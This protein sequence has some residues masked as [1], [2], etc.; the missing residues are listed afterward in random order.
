MIVLTG[1]L[2]VG[3]PA[4]AQA[5]PT[6]PTTPT[7]TPS[8]TAGTGATQAP[9]PVDGAKPADGQPD[10]VAPVPGTGGSA[11][12]APAG[13]PERDVTDVDEGAESDAERAG[14][15]SGTDRFETA[16]QLSKSSFPGTA[17]V[18][19]IATGESFAD[20][21]SA[22]PAAV[23]VGGPLLL[24]YRDDLPATVTAEIKRVNPT[25]IIVVGGTAAVSMRVEQQLR[26]LAPYLDRYSG[27]DR[28]ATSMTVARCAWSSRFNPSVVM[29]ETSEKGFRLCDRIFFGADTA[30]LAVGSNFPDALA[31]GAAAGRI[32]APV[33]V[34]PTSNR[35]SGGWSTNFDTA[36]LSPDRIS[37]LR[38]VGGYNALDSE[39][40]Q[41]ASRKKINAVR[42]SGS[43][44]Y[45]TAVAV[46]SYSFR[47]AP[48]V[49]L[50]TGS[51]FPDA[52]AGAAAAGKRGAPLYLS[53]GDCVPESVLTDLDRLGLKTPSKV[54]LI[55]GLN[56]LDANVEQLG[57]C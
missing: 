54:T 49:Y 57:R 37:D 33:L 55:G 17:P 45:D 8:A 42:L 41:I 52:L 24:T 43:T 12:P 20:A 34:G 10:E 48:E 19:V 47:Q 56:A 36:L 14:R 50:A 39:W 23:K 1:L 31:A 13:G 40:E 25:Q 9:V 7:P 15:V 27:S 28:Y 32:A 35:G 3:V 11:E 53:Q 46:N 26:S 21:L 51:N 30:Y 18:V 5:A 29:T 16:V 2:S 22:G 4:V 6:P 44:R 38:I